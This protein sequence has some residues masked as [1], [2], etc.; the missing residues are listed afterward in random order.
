MLKHTDELKTPT[1]DKF[2]FVLRLEDKTCELKLAEQVKDGVEDWVNWDDQLM[3]STYEV[4]TIAEAAQV[5]QSSASSP[6]CNV[7]E[8]DT[9]PV[10]AI[11]IVHVDDA[12]VEHEDVALTQDTGDVVE[13]SQ[14][15]PSSQDSLTSS[16]SRT[17]TPDSS[18][19][20]TDLEAQRKARL[21]RSH[22]GM[23]FAS[24]MASA[25]L[26]DDKVSSSDSDSNSDSDE[27]TDEDEDRSSAL[28]VPRSSTPFDNE[29]TNVEEN[30]SST[31]TSDPSLS[32]DYTSDEE[33]DNSFLDDIDTSPT[34][35]ISIIVLRQKVTAQ[36]HTPEEREGTCRHWKRAKH[37]GAK[38]VHGRSSLRQEVLITQDDEYDLFFEGFDSARPSLLVEML[39]L[40]SFPTSTFFLFQ[41][42]E[43]GDWG[44]SMLTSAGRGSTS[45]RGD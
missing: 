44:L 10:P 13:G 39:R 31:P 12:E 35:D 30:A 33:S 42:F 9:L 16:G 41:G 40:V 21:M 36:D 17:S 38:F 5:A 8:D 19:D 18:L 32:P 37:A 45:P 3:E 11:Q 2:V 1:G 43:D 6:E 34:P 20:D 22:K 15:S 25:S 7:V 26:D 28:A 29:S 24:V 14:P 23:S 27:D 4:V